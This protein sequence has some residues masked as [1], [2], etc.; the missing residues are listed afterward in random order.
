MLAL[1]AS[2]AGD[3]I[4]ARVGVAT[5]TMRAA[6]A[7]RMRIG[8]LGHLVPFMARGAGDAV[9]ARIVMTACAM[10]SHKPGLVGIGV[11]SDRVHFM[12]NRATGSARCALVA[13]GAMTAFP[14]GIMRAGAYFLMA[15]VA[16]VGLMAYLATIAIPRGLHAMGLV[17]PQH[18][19]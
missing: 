1:V 14:V 9:K 7:G 4:E 5:C 16:R 17:H 3:A 15:S 10:R 11:F 18:G 6:E 8:V 2:G 12:A 13:L 19:V